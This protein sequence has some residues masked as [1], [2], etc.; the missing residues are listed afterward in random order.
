MALH[1]RSNFLPN[2]EHQPRKGGTKRDDTPTCQQTEEDRDQFAQETKHP[3]AHDNRQSPTRLGKS[4]QQLPPKQT[5]RLRAAFD[6]A[7]SENCPAIQNSPAK[8]DSIV[9]HATPHS[10][11]LKKSTDFEEK[12]HVGKGF[13]FFS[14]PRESHS[15]IAADSLPRTREAGPRL[16][17]GPRTRSGQT[18]RSPMTR[19]GK[20]RHNPTANP[21]R[22]N[23]RW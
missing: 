7:I 14:H 15:H 2:W 1:P 6:V 9:T 5:F 4:D 13:V 12:R 10:T 22:H 8:S 17:Y 21:E 11:Q 18:E 19:Y 16:P 23:G 3:N 20:N